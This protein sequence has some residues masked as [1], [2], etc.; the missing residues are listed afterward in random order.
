MAIGEK[1]PLTFWFVRP[2][3][4]EPWIQMPEACGQEWSKGRG[5][6]VG[7]RATSRVRGT[8]PRFAQRPVVEQRDLKETAVQI[9]KAQGWRGSG[10]ELDTLCRHYCRYY[11]QGQR[12]E[13][14]ATGDPHTLSPLLGIIRQQ[15]WPA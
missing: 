8:S 4:F 1:D 3:F 13:G 14:R 2:L 7:G 6:D 11:W 10:E 12:A 9:A 15:M 5:M